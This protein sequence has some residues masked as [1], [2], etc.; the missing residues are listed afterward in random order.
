MILMEVN[1]TT[2]S[3][4]AG[5]FTL[6]MNQELPDNLFLSFQTVFKFGMSVGFGAFEGYSSKFI[7]EGELE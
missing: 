1:P 4:F 5:A 7:P 3:A 2:G 6:V